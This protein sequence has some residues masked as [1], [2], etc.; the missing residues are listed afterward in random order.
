LTLAS[1]AKFRQ[2]LGGE[3]EII[4]YTSN[5]ARTGGGLVA[6]EWDSEILYSPGLSMVNIRLPVS[7]A[8]VDPSKMTVFHI[9]LL[10]KHSAC[11]AIYQHDGY[12]WVR[13]S[14]QIY[15]EEKDFIQFAKLVKDELSYVNLNARL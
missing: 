12:Y 14:A 13:L 11:C 8:L 7:P 4:K 15:N 9:H 5:L 6:R 1:A 10:K 3:N 2:V